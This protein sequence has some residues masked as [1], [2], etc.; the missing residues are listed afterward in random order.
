MNVTVPSMRPPPYAVAS[1]IDCVPVN[2]LARQS[3]RHER[4]VIVGAGKTGID[5]CL[6]LLRQDIDPADIVW[7]MPRAIPWLIDR[8]H[9]QPGPRFSARP[10]RPAES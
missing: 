1:G 10:S 6:W 5:A 2:A 7:I 3:R 9:V 8:S 4:Y